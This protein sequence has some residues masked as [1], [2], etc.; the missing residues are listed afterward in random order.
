MTVLPAHVGRPDATMREV[1][2]T[3]PRRVRMTRTLLLALA[4]LALTVVTVF[5]TAR[6]EAFHIYDLERAYVA[7]H[8]GNAPRGGVQMPIPPLTT[9]LIRSSGQV[10]VLGLSWLCFTG[11]LCL[12]SLLLANGELR[13]GTC[14]TIVLWSWVPYAFRGLLQWVY[15]LVTR[16]PIYN[17]GLSGLVLD[18]A[19]LPLGTYTYAMP[20]TAQRTWAAL[21]SRVDIYLFLH[22]AVFVR[23][24]AGVTNWGRRRALMVGGAIWLVWLLA[25]MAPGY[26]FQ[27]FSRIRFW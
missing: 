12:L 6:A 2:G 1:K 13:F 11:A 22:L 5:V 27:F 14:L 3:A 20:T 7:E 18:S 24:I 21:L 16:D 26:F 8:P 23:G 4:I 15:M 25:S 17:P 10:M 19:P 9:L